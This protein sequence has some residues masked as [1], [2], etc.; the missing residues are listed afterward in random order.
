MT[1]AGAASVALE[2]EVKLGAEPEFVLPDLDET[3]H[4]LRAEP[5]PERHLDAV[6]YDTADLRLL[7]SAVTVRS[8]TDRD[9]GVT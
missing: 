6:Y 7:R 1:P 8:R 2:R 9:T 4:D 5:V 3:G